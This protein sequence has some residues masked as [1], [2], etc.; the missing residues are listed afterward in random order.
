MQRSRSYA[1]MRGVFHFVSHMIVPVCCHR[2]EI[3]DGVACGAV[4]ACR[5]RKACNLVDALLL[6]H[7]CMNK[8]LRLDF[9]NEGT[10]HSVRAPVTLLA[11]LP[12]PWTTQALILLA[13]GFG[14]GGHW[15]RRHVVTFDCAGMSEKGRT[16]STCCIRRLFISNVAYAA[17]RPAQASTGW[18]KQVVRPVSPAE[19]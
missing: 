5:A 14:Q 19:L 11:T 3:W 12:M 7:T 4:Q 1:R 9:F 2:W 8:Y 16:C 17:H 13:A 15:W 18:C 10:M 6:R